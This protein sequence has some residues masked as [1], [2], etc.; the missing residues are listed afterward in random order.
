MTVVQDTSGE[1]FARVSAMIRDT[2]AVLA[3]LERG[4]RNPW[5]REVVQ[6]FGRGRCSTAGRWDSRD[7]AERAAILRGRMGE[8]LG[9]VPRSL[10]MQREAR[11]A[12]YWYVGQF[13]Q[14]TCFQAPGVLP[15]LYQGFGELAQD[16]GRVGLSQL[17]ARGVIMCK[18][19]LE[20]LRVRLDACDPF[21]TGSHDEEVSRM[22]RD[23]RDNPCL[24]DLVTL[25]EAAVLVGVTKA[26]ISQLLAA[27]RFP[28][29]AG[30]VG[31]ASVWHRDTVLE[32]LEDR[33]V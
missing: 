11:D 32:W 29:P 2:E 16:M 22:V 6:G 33:D 5:I 20:D 26:R 23:S 30:V 1:S 12:W 14:G 25:T 31:R 21:D 13:A 18:W 8:G 9:G 3:R 7:Q 28:E 27:G 24:E 10:D 17:E 19:K 15:M 4:K